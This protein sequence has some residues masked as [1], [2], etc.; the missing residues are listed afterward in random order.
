MERF[1]QISPPSVHQMLL[2]LEE[3]GLIS[4]VPGEPRS[5]RLLVSAEELPHPP[6]AAP[7]PFEP[8]P[9][10]PQASVPAKRPGRAPAPIGPQRAAGAHQPEQL[11][12][13]AMPADSSTGTVA[14]TP[15]E[16]SAPPPM[17][18]PPSGLATRRRRARRN[19]DELETFGRSRTYA[20]RVV[21][22][23]DRKV[24]RIIEVRGDQSL[25]HL[26]QG[27]QEAFDWDDDHLYSFFMSGKRWDPNTEYAAPGAEGSPKA[28]RVMI[29][30]LDIEPRRRFLYLFDYGDELLH[31]VWLVSV[32]PAADGV[33]YPRVVKSQGEAPP[34][35]P[36]TDEP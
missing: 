5:I 31:D 35:Y 32:G 19:P 4:R 29:C 34:Q 33:R 8:A 3:R 24:W 14:G 16:D 23:W 1:F 15:L 12:L 10:R 6:G 36:A 25:H 13:F 17:E 18:V 30:T 7:R 11:T 21:L 22:K 28:N 9:A 2:R 20:F 27:I 26:H